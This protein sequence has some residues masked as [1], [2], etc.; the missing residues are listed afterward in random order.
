MKSENAKTSFGEDS[1][2]F[3]ASQVMLHNI[4][5]GIIALL[6]CGV[7]YLFANK[8]FGSGSLGTLLLLLYLYNLQLSSKQL[9]TIIALKLA[10]RKTKFKTELGALIAALFV[11]ISIA[12][13]AI[14]R[15][16]LFS[17]DA[18]N[19]FL[20]LVFTLLSTGMVAKV[21][22]LIPSSRPGLSIANQ[23]PVPD[24]SLDVGNQY[25]CVPRYKLKRLN[26]LYFIVPIAVGV[27]LNLLILV[28]I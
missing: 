12:V 21:G 13:I 23:S 20:L 22:N 8:N 4:I 2:S 24:Q 6:A 17:D 11:S 26:I 15:F 14:I 10:K 9:Y 7:V 28:F 27:L 16:D 1:V 25:F 18:Q 3:G 19:K 5:L